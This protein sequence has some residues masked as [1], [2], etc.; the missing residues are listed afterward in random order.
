MLFER[1]YFVHYYDSDIKQRLTISSLMK[2][3][4][5]V[6]IL[7]SEDAGIGLKYYE[8]KKVA[9]VLYKWGIIIN[10]Y[11]KFKETI[12]VRTR[13]VSLNGFKAYR[14]FDILDKSGN[15]IVVANSM[16]L[17]V[18]TNTKR[19]IKIN[20]DMFTHYG[21]D[22]NYKEELQIEEVRTLNKI[23][24]EKDFY[25]RYSDIDTNQHVNNIAYVNW[26]MEVIPENIIKDYTLKELN[27]VYKKE[28]KLGNMIKSSVEIKDNNNVIECIHLISENGIELCGLE[29]KWQYD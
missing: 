9:W 4:E 13:A 12:K 19:P 14:Y 23:D 15:Q 16:W 21:V 29:T 22:H 25:I 24:A 26:A 18:N 5:D 3:F 7:H 6:A 11:P 20:E 27:V 8:Q 10:H 2:Y 17:F 1:N 28:T